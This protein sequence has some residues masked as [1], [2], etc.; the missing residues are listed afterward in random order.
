MEEGVG[1]RRWCR[2]RLL[3]SKLNK[4]VE[5]TKRAD[6]EERQGNMAE[7]NNDCLLYKTKLQCQW[8]S[9][10][11]DDTLTSNAVCVCV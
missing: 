2:V 3:T 5:Q 8:Q 7:T 6:D 10:I 9:D 11:C 1:W 4:L